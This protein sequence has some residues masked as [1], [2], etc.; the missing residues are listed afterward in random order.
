MV[1][2]SQGQPFYDGWFVQLLLNRGDGTFDDVTADR[3][4]VGDRIGGRA[5]VATGTPYVTWVKVIDF[6]G[7]GHPDFAVEYSLAPFS[8][9][10]WLPRSTPLIFLNDGTGRFST[11]KVSDFV[12]PGSESAV[13]YG[14]LVRTRQGYGFVTLNLPPWLPRQ[15]LVLTGLVASKPFH[16]RR[17]EPP[18]LF[19]VR[20]SGSSVALTWFAPASGSPASE[21]VVEAGSAPG[22]SD[23]ANVATG[24]RSTAF[25]ATGVPAGRYYVRVRASGLA[26]RSAPSNELV[27][28]VGSSGDA[29]T[30]P[31]SPPPLSA[32]VSGSKV[33]LSWPAVAGATYHVLHAGSASG[34]SDVASINLGSAPGF[35][36]NGVGAGV[37]YVRLRAGNS[38]GT[39]VPSNEV[40]VT[41]R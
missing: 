1:V 33:T 18:A 35:V 17:P 40:A 41:V 7:D 9:I 38:C 28:V 2:G 37:Y 23:L 20:S 5:G 30:G 29:C 10:Q 34:E 12:A 21:Y 27:H 19:E 14:H 8:T 4:A 32:S 39:G 6:N 26:G 24:T 13:G 16:L 3:L 36:A 15:G 11:L 25:L 31:P 22:S